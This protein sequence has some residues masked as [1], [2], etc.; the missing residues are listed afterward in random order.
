[1]GREVRGRLKRER[2]YVSLLLIHVEVWQI[3]THHCREIIL[4]LKINKYSLKSPFFFVPL[5]ML[6]YVLSFVPLYQS[7][8]FL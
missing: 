8:S 4:Q 1:M 7:I 2:T 3:P 6:S 5:C